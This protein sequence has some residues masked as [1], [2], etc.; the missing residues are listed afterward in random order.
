MRK[1]LAGKTIYA[2]T[3]ALAIG[4]MSTMANAQ[5]TLG[6]ALSFAVL[7]DAGPVIMGNSA[8]LK[9]APA[10]VGASYNIVIGGN[11]SSYSGDVISSLFEQGPGAQIKLNNY[12][13]VIGK[14]V[15]DGGAIV[16][17]SGAT[18][19]GGKVLNP[20]APEIIVLESALNQEE[21]W[22]DAVNCQSPTQTIPAINLGAGKNQ[23]ILTVPGLNVIS[24]PNITLGNSATL[25]ISGS[26]SDQVILITPG[27]IKLN[28]GSKIVLIGGLQPQNVL[29]DAATEPQETG[30]TSTQL[31]LV[32]I[33][34]SG[35]LFGTLHCGNSCTFGSGVNVTGAII[36]DFGLTTGPNLRL[37]FA[38]LTGISLPACEQQQP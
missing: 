31:G 18:C 21:V 13:H 24:T 16:L 3:V 20:V 27:N 30:D 14:C 10:H 17:G 29:I 38:P 28:F 8:T 25:R 1:A 4:L 36:G 2:A 34:N 12:A 5:V 33:A 7:G 15:T 6:D 9:G 37:T 35:S 23:T 11:N 32:N 22:D 19:S 26:I